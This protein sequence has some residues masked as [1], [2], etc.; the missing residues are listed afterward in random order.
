MKKVVAFILTIVFVLTAFAACGTTPDRSDNGSETGSNISQKVWYLG[1]N[2]FFSHNDEVKPQELFEGVKDSVN[3]AEAYANF[4]FDDEALWGSYT[5]NNIEE[6]VK[7][8]RESIPFEDVSFTNGTFN[9]STLPIEVF[10]GSE[11]VYNSLNEYM[12]PQLKDVDEKNVAV[13]AFATENEI[14]YV[15]CIYDVSVSSREIVFTVIDYNEETKD[16]EFN[17]EI[18]D[19]EFVYSFSLDGADLTL[20]NGKSSLTLTSYCFTENNE[21]GISISAYAASYSPLIDEL[22]HFMYITGADL[23]IARTLKNDNYDCAACKFT[24]DGRFTIYLSRKDENGEV[25]TVIKQFCAIFQSEVNLLSAPN[26]S[27]VFIEAENAYYYNRTPNLRE[28]ES[29]E[30]DNIDTGTLTDEQLE[31]IA[32]KKSDLFDDLYDEFKVRGLNVTINRQTGEIGLDTAILF[33]G[34]SAELTDSG[35]ALLD[36][37]VAVY[38]SIIYNDKY[39]GFIKKIMVE[40][41]TAPTADKSY[42]DDLPLSEERADNVKAYCLS[43]YTGAN[44]SKLASQ[45]E[46]VGYSNSRPVYNS[47]HAIDVNACRR[48]SFRFIVDTTVV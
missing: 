44:V 34:D 16:S 45:L 7:K 43:S 28:K 21:K 35:K 41:H 26:L 20:S 9:I 3:L 29:L 23:N 22:D 1:G 33:S 19:T 2:T 12:Y 46:A 32:E 10:I 24:K 18:T 5:L 13:L 39:D 17:L 6:D 38:T 15:P 48:V 30:A 27:F 31:A 40:G 42:E 14:G 11:Y 37:F 36:K 8:V 47:D 4:Q 25:K